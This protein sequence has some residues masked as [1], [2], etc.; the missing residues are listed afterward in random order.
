[1]NNYRYAPNPIGWV[2]PFGLTCK[3]NSWNQFQKRSKGVFENSSQ[4]STGYHSWQDQDWG[5]L[6]S[7]L[8]SNSWPPNRGAVQS[9]PFT[10]PVDQEIDRYGGW[11]DAAGFHDSGT[12]VSPVGESFPSRALP[13]ATLNK[14]YRKYKVV[15]PI[16]AEAAEAIPWFGQP[17][18]GT[19]YELPAG[20]DDLISSGYLVPT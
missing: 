7:L 2:D 16:Q 5:T 15:K 1:M 6:E 4:A 8:P 3:E 9:R 19:Q 17:G 12:F 13:A 18:M 11:N 14:P 10:I 20:I